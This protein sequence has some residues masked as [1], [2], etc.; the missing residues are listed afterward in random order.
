MASSTSMLRRGSNSLAW[1]WNSIKYSSCSSLF[2][3]AASLWK[4]MTLPALSPSARKRPVWSNLTTE[5]MSSS[6]IFSP[7]PL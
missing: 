2:L 7:G 4:T 3:V 6:S 1:D 5:M